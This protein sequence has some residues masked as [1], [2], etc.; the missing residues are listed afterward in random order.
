[1]PPA[2]AALV[3][4]SWIRIELEMEVPRALQPSRRPLLHVDS[5]IV[6]IYTHERDL[7]RDAWP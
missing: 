6:T 7:F 2:L 3:G 5:G 4:G 1:M